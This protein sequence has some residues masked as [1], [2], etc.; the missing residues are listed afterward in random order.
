MSET[1]KDHF[2]EVGDF[3]EMLEDAGL[4]AETGWEEDFVAELQ[5]RYDQYNEK[6]FLSG[7]QVEVLKRIAYG[8]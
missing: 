4:N 5:E 3:D 6:T 2:D 1:I 8:E 7:K